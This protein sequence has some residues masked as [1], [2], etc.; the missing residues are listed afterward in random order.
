[1]SICFLCFGYVREYSGGTV[2][3]PI[4]WS[5]PCCFPFFLYFLSTDLSSSCVNCPS[6]MSNWLLIIFGIGSCVTFGGFLSKYSTYCFYRGFRSSWL[7]AFSLAFAVLF[8]LPTSFTIC[9]VILD[10]L[11]SIESLILL[12]WF[13]MYFVYSFRHMLVNSFLSFLALIL[14]GFLQM[15]L[16]AVF[17]YARFFRTTNVSN[18]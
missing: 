18:V 7:V 15:H 14:V 5:Y 9:H 10:C 3:R 11:F 1:M 13:C 4:P 8:L 6:L 17:P 12:I 16:E 2:C